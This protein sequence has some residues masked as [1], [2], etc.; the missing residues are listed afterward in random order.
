MLSRTTQTTQPAR[1]AMLLPALSQFQ[2]PVALLGVGVFAGLCECPDY[3]CY[4]CDRQVFLAARRKATE[5]SVFSCEVNPK[6]PL[7]NVAPE[8]SR[9][10]ALDL[11]LLDI[12]TKAQIDWLKTL[13]WPDV[14]VRNTP[15]ILNTGDLLDDLRGPADSSPAN[16]QWVVF[17]TAVLSYVRETSQPAKFANLMKDPDAIWL[18]NEAPSVFPEKAQKAPPPPQQDGFLTSVSAQPVVWT[19]PHGQYIHRFGDTPASATR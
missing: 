19:G 4:D 8:I 15:Q 2:Q 10:A 16:N 1:C 17:H 18:S 6:T 7:P 12:A 3:C 5:P 14:F 9:R 13:V 11:N